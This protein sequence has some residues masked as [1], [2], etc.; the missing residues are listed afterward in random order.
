M[1]T[2]PGYPFRFE[3][4]DRAFKKLVETVLE[5]IPLEPEDFPIFKIVQAD[6]NTDTWGHVEDA[7]AVWLDVKAMNRRRLN[8]DA[9]I[10]CIAH[11]FAHL[12]LQHHSGEYEHEDEAELE[13][14]E[15]AADEKAIE[16]GF[17]KEIRAKEK[18]RMKVKEHMRSKSVAKS[19]RIVIQQKT[20]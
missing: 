16:W 12:F 20:K 14:V 8:V 7:E 9:K 1:K 18:F 19:E 10:G 6:L 17:G 2:K 11:E 3:V 15:K 5:K 13:E 4:K